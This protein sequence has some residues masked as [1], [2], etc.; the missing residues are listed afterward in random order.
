MLETIRVLQLG[1]EDW[2]ECYKLPE[3]VDLTHATLFKEAPRTPYDIVFV[4][5][6][7]LRQE[8]KA[9]AK[10][11]KAHTLFVTEGLELNAAMQEYYAC[12]KGK[13]IVKTEIQDFL[14]HE[15]RNYF[16][17]PYGEKFRLGN[18]SVAQGFTGSVSWNGNYSVILEGEFDEKLNQIAFWRNNIPIFQGQAID[19]WLEYKKDPTV[20]IALVVT[21]FRQGSISEVQQKWAFTEDELQDV[22]VVD[23][24]MATGPVFVSLLAKGSGRLEIIALH[25]RY[26]RRGHGAFLP[27]G[28]RYVTSAREEV[29]Y[30]FDPGDMKPP[31]NVYFSGYKTLQGFE[32]YYMM[33]KMG[34]PFLLIA[35]PRLEG[36]SFYMGSEE[37]EKGLADIIRM[38]MD[39]LGFTRDQ[40]ILSGLSMGTYGALY[41]GC[42]I[43]PHAMILGKPLAS[44]GDVAENERLHRPGGFPTSLD[45]LNYLI[46]DTDE[47]AIKKL[48]DKFWNKFDATDWGQSKFVVAYMIEDDYDSRAYDMI[49]SHV[50]NEGVQVYGKGIHGRHNDATGAIAGWFKSQ[51]EEILN[52][53]FSRRVE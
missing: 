52:R 48:N 30:Y 32:G 35:E 28:E 47:E 34:C 16:P 20:E 23:N 50:K 22:V 33:R 31:L 38:H 2:N 51:Y 10:A 41:Y 49:I 40:V 7:L 17:K 12:K 42:D 43:L 11:T 24:Q 1:T 26:S 21:Q 44:I 8:M 53:D 45:V 46:G 36:G 37:Y 4:D 29:F 5:R 9:L 25:D 6:P 13:C 18:L 27:G 15:A 3:Y 19:F 14:L 39:E